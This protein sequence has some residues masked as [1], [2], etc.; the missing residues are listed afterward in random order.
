MDVFD[1]VSDKPGNDIGTQGRHITC[2]NCERPNYTLVTRV[3]PGK[4]AVTC[5]VEFHDPKKQ[6]TEYYVT[7]MD[8]RL[9]G[10]CNTRL[11]LY[12]KVPVAPSYR[13][14]MT[15]M[16]LS[17]SQQDRNGCRC[18][19]TAI[20]KNGC[21]SNIWFS[22]GEQFNPVLHTFEGQLGDKA[23]RQTT[24]V[25]WKQTAGKHLYPE[26][27]KHTETHDGKL[28]YEEIVT[29]QAADFVTPIDPSVFTFAGLELNDD[30]QLAF[31]E[32]QPG[33]W[34]VWKDGRVDPSRSNRAKEKEAQDAQKGAVQPGPV[35]PVA[36]YP[37]QSS[38][39]LIV[40]LV[41]G[42][43]SVTALGLAAIYRR[44]KG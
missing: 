11:S 31:P 26:R 21:K 23:A 34:P 38:T 10:L 18:L 8:W 33:D 9:L 29:V 36:A 40:G 25:K 6:V 24:E 42:G 4:P 30:Q 43:M 3:L 20:E 41:S 1:Q 7:D 28:H 22:Q 39:P 19:V 12:R 44:R 13:E 15:D 16:G 35:A 14:L 2:R 5:Q 27:I 17:T 32:L 37:V